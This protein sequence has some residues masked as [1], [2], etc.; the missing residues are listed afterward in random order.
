MESFAG[1]SVRDDAS[2]V[3]SDPEQP[4][5]PT[6]FSGLPSITEGV[7]YR[8]LFQQRQHLHL[9]AAAK[10]ILIMSIRTFIKRYDRQNGGKSDT[11]FNRSDGHT[12]H[13]GPKEASR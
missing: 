4:P 13:F 9:R 5:A 1:T 11:N 7:A 8:I 6:L 2:E 3:A 12:P 10:A